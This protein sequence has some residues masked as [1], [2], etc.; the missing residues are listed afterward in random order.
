MI[1]AVIG[2]EPDHHVVAAR[3]FDQFLVGVSHA[4]R[5]EDARARS[6]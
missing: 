2:V 6:D 4:R 1:G 3:G 5:G